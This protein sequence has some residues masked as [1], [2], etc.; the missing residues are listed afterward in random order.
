MTYKSNLLQ[1]SSANTTFTNPVSI[2]I[3]H[4]ETHTMYREDS[5]AAT[6]CLITVFDLYLNNQLVNGAIGTLG[7]WTQ[8]EQ[9]PLLHTMLPSAE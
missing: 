3:Q 6:L 2:Y 7:F 4:A 8:L 9:T 1:R 5:K